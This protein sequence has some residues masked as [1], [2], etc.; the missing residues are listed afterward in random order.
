MVHTRATNSSSLL[1]DSEIDR[2]LFRVRKEV[3]DHFRGL[4]FSFEDPEATEMAERPTL[5]ELTAPNL[6]QQP[7]AVQF[8]ELADDVNFELKSG[9]IH[10]LPQFHGLSREDP[11]KHL[12][13]FHAVCISMKPKGV[14]ED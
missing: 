8:P 2:P 3:R 13:E 5:R 9:L 11:N 6:Q 4:P 14:I 7:L 10:L 1:F 12:A